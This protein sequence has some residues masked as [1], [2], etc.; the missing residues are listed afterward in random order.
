MVSGKSG[1]LV[2]PTAMVNNLKSAMQNQ[3]TVMATLYSPVELRQMREF[4][5]AL[6]AVSYK[7]PNASGSGYSAAQFAKD[8]LLKILDSFGLGT[9]A[10]AALQYTGIGNAL[11]GA[12]AKQAVSAISRPVRP[13]VTPFMTAAGQA[14]YQ[15]QS[16]GR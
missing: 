15:S 11:S 5:R 3:S 4:V 1:E 2:G 10:R 6:E 7:P 13:N 12:S 9:P 16:G 14:G 8:G